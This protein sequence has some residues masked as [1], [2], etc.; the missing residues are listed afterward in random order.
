MPELP[1][2]AAYMTASNLASS[3]SRSF[4]CASRAL[5]CFEP[6]NRQLKV[7][8]GRIVRELRRIGKRIAIGIE[9][10]LWL[11]LH[12]M[13]AGRLH[14]R[15]PQAKLAGRN[16]LAAFDFPNGSLVLT[17]AGTKHRASFVCPHGRGRF[18]LHRPGR[19]RNL[20]RAIST[21]FAKRLRLKTAHSSEPLPIRA[22]SVESATRIRM[23]F[24]TPRSSRPSPSRA[25]WNRTNGK[26]CSPRRAIPRALDRPAERGGRSWLSRKITAFRKGN[27]G[28]RTLRTALPK[29]RREDSADS[30]RGQR[31]KLLRPLP[32]WWKVLADR[33]L[34][35]LLGSDWPRT[36]EEL[37]ALKRR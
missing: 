8:E 35:R 32:N 14:W 16:S 20:L 4:E 5:F 1:D 9:A 15:P 30:L 17:E 23:K 6:R 2:I 26:S 22:L 24:C 21:R 13:I 31:N 18:A 25:N 19:N 37:E 10:D 11:V 36:L 12:L 34:S 29:V 7:W 33:A 27:G 3:R 28:S